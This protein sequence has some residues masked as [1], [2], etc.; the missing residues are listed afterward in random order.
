[1]GRGG[2]QGFYKKQSKITLRLK[3]LEAERKKGVEQIG[4]SR[5]KHSPC[6]GLHGT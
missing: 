4:S 5:I 2:K 1:V 3:R 6:K